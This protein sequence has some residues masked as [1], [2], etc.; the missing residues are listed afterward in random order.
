MKKFFKN[1]WMRIWLLCSF[2]W[3]VGFNV[4]CY[5]SWEKTASV[6]KLLLAQQEE[7]GVTFS[8]EVSME[9]S[10]KYKGYWLMYGVY[11]FDSLDSQFGIYWFSISCFGPSLVGLIF[12]YGL[13]WIIVGFKSQTT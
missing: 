9:N 6:A 11:G 4:W 1:P 12:I 8:H 2:L 7:A 3:I 13:R 5:Y 10:R